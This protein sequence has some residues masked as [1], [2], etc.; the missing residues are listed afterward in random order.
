ML[1]SEFMT[2]N[3]ISSKADITVKEAAE[4]MFKN[5]ISCLPVVDDNENLIGIITESDF[6][7][8]EV[9]VPHAM[10]S[11]KRILGETFHDASIDDVFEKAKKHTL[12]DVMSKNLH[13]VKPDS[14]LT[15]VVN[16]MISKSYKRLPVVEDGKLV[17]IITRKDILRAFNQAA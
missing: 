1:A 14:T 10:V 6:V 16:Y 2:K 7:G 13:T 5:N 8:K 3:V 9:N 4:I 12:A 17:G 15:D 11:I